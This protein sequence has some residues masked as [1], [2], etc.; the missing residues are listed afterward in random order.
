MLSSEKLD[1]EEA[2]SQGRY[3]AHTVVEEAFGVS[4]SPPVGVAPAQPN[5]HTAARAWGRVGRNLLLICGGAIA[6]IVGIGSMSANDKLVEKTWASEST[7]EDV[8]FTEPF[9]VPTDARRSLD[10]KLESDVSRARA[11]VHLALINSTTG[12]AYLPVD[13][14]RKN[15]GSGRIGLPQPGEYLGR[16]EVAYAPGTDKAYP[17]S[18]RLEVSRDT[19]WFLPSCLIFLFGLL[20]P[21]AVIWSYLRFENK[22]WMNSDHAG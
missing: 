21:V 2:W 11:Q 8:F 1:T 20:A 15:E 19:P 22:R 13:T 6:L 16:V 17:G 4:L 3:L 9:V 10:V 7:T 14:T 5:P 12:V 18:V